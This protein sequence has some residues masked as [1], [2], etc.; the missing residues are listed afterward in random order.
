MLS[1]KQ[2]Q[3][4]FENSFG[5]WNFPPV[6]R[7]FGDD[8]G[9][10]LYGDENPMEFIFGLGGNDIIYAGQYDFLYGGSGND[11]LVG[12][13]GGNTFNP[14]AGYDT[15]VLDDWGSSFRDLIFDF[16]AAQDK[17]QLNSSQFTGLAQGTLSEDLFYI[18]EKG[19]NVW[20]PG[21]EDRFLYDKT[22]HTLE[23]KTEDGALV[24]VAELT[25]ASGTPDLSHLNF[26]IV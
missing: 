21:A 10:V 13:K 18:G 14:E 15:I 12:A 22:Y 5:Y 17:V 2:D 26:F 23:Y 11:V 9:N 6:I 25:K 4:N 7:K 3:V 24:T 19:K 8:T 20:N 16:N 1:L